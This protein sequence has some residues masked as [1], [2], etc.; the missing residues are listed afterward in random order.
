LAVEI[1]KAVADGIIVVFSAGNGHYGF[2][3]SLPE[4]ISA[5]GTYSDHAKLMQASD[6]ASAFASA[7]YPGR[8]VPDVCGLVGMQPHADYI[9]LPIPPGCEI[10]RECAFFDGTTPMDG[11]ALF[12]GTSASAPQIAGACALL[13]QANPGLSPSEIK[14]V[15][16]R[17]AKDVARGRAN[18]ASDEA[19]QGLPAGPG[20]D[21][22]TGAGL[23]D[24]AH[25]LRQV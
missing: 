1:Q 24:I 23:I 19:G 4:V 11:W 9:L 15:L 13:K 18:P 10:D 16:R 14:Q 7:V 2:P 6:Y 17:T 20:N 12:S 22:A 3:G 5:G 25:A 8:H 21:R